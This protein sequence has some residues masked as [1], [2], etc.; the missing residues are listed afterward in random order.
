MENRVLE[1]TYGEFQREDSGDYD[2]QI[3]VILV[4]LS[5]EKR[6]SVKAGI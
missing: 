3:E 6:Q 4:L 5:F 1:G 2:E